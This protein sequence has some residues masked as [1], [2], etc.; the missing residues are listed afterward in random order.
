[1]H[2]TQGPAGRKGDPG[3][4]G[5]N[6]TAGP[7][8]DAGPPGPPGVGEPGPAGPPGPEG[9]AGRAG[10]PGDDGQPGP[11]VSIIRIFVAAHF[12]GSSK[13]MKLT[14]MH[15]SYILQYDIISCLRDCLLQY[16]H[17]QYVIQ[18]SNIPLSL[19]F[20][21]IPKMLLLL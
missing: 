13:K 11:P 16:V 19:L 9:P 20:S 21:V 5:M 6:G 4:P 14:I 1:M 18:S 17:V 2:H 15:V 12:E 10:K 7:P 3:D 8:G